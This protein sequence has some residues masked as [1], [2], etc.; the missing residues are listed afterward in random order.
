MLSK[1]QKDQFNQL[2]DYRDNITNSMFHIE[3]ILKT[4]FPE[5]FDIAYQHYIPQIITA[6]Y[7]DERWLPRGQTNMQ[8]SINR[9]S[10]KIID[11]SGRGVSKFIK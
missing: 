4:H 5:E 11:S 1:E 6:L 8:Q 10:D 7:D 2:L 9:I 3:R